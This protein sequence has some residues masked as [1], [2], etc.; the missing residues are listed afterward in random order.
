MPILPLEVT[1]SVKSLTFHC[2]ACKLKVPVATGLQ[3]GARPHGPQKETSFAL[4]I[5]DRSS[6]RRRSRSGR[7]HRAC[8]PES[9]GTRCPGALGVG[10]RGGSDRLESRGGHRLGTVARE[11][12]W[13]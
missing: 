12:G 3:L 4:L 7:R 5:S 8:L 11:R 2:T 10:R 1:E 6:G 9:H 13:I